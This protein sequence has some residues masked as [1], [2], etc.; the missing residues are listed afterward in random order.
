M[1]ALA[2]EG[3]GGP[4]RAGNAESAFAAS[5]RPA[6]SA[7]DEEAAR[8]AVDRTD[9]AIA[10]ALATGT[11]TPI[12]DVAQALRD[13]FRTVDRGL[14]IA[15]AEAISARAA[16]QTKLDA[17]R[18]EVKQRVL[19]RQTR[20]GTRATAVAVAIP[21]PAILQEPGNDDQLPRVL[22][23]PLD[24]VRLTSPF[25]HRVGV[26]AHEAMDVKF[27]DGLD[28]QAAEGTPL[29]PCGTG[30]VIFAGPRGGYGLM[31]IVD[32]GG[33]VTTQ[34]AHLSAIRISV[35]DTVGRDDVIGLTGS[36]GRST[37][38]HLHLIATVDGRKV[39]PVDV[40]DVPL[41]EVRSRSGVRP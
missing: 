38:P 20:L 10:E 27:H 34:Y 30:K 1:L 24:D 35:G 3:C 4:S 11:L 37:A 26:F 28:L 14:T 33:G 31:V 25:G 18:V 41:D 39:D 15:P 21:A 17:A 7:D 13:A 9:V 32:H 36:T 29:H 12:I 2:L 16:A 5:V 6:W 22:K 8:A 40:I 19:A 23:W